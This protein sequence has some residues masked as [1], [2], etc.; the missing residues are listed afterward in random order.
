MRAL[1]LFLLLAAPLLSRAETPTKP[2][3]LL[4]S[5]NLTGWE[6]VVEPAA[7]IR[8]VC[9][10]NPDGSLAVTGKPVSFIA[11]KTSYENYSLHAE[12]RWLAG[13]PGNGGILLHIASGPKDRQWP[14]SLQVQLKNKAVGDLIPMAGATFAEPLTTPVGSAT[15]FRAHD[16][17]DAEKPVGEWNSAD[18]ACRSD[19]VEVTINGIRQSR[20]TRVAPA[21][22][23]IGFQLEGVAY[24][25]RNV[26]IAP[27]PKAIG[28]SPQTPPGPGGG[29]GR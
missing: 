20:I 13:K 18:I 21:A 14:V 3:A 29:F 5:P 28:S 16:G 9:S 24:E 22:G 25:L 7:D 11:T 19:V 4:R 23:K 1:R 15:M 2:V 26:R 12:W 8:T 17:A 10:Y 27:L 6:L